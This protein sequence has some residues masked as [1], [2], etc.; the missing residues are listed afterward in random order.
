MEKSSKGKFNDGWGRGGGVLVGELRL[1]PIY[2]AY[3]FFN[4]KYILS[5][6]QGWANGKIEIKTSHS[7]AKTGIKYCFDYRRC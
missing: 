2:S 3:H 6:I 5:G 7:E 1:F 4:L